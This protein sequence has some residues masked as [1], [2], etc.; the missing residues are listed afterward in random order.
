M[1]I[2]FHFLP[3]LG[4]PVKIRTE[5]SIVLA[6]NYCPFNQSDIY[7]MSS[8]FLMLN[9]F[10][11]NVNSPC[12]TPNKG[13]LLAVFRLRLDKVLSTPKWAHFPGFYFHKIYL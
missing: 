3:N 11:K 8:T 2:F 5:L 4:V 10:T 1:N 13:F 9:I 12:E 6:Q 7:K